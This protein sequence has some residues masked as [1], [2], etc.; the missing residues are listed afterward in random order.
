MVLYKMNSTLHYISAVIDPATE[1]KSAVG[2][3]YK[4]MPTQPKESTT[5]APKTTTTKE[6]SEKVTHF[7]RTREKG[8]PFPW[9]QAT[10]FHPLWCPGARVVQL[11]EAPTVV[12]YQAHVLFNVI[13]GCPCYMNEKGGHNAAATA[14]NIDA[15]FGE[16]FAKERMTRHWFEKFRSGDECLEDEDR[17]WP[18]SLLNDEQ[19]K[20]MVE[21]HPR[22]AV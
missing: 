5:P 16:N 15:A 1:T 20:A 3:K 14:R 11:E 4:N 18:P 9:R 7:L 22:R 2:D 17:G 6:K 8:E 10:K 12:L 21:A 19:L 13:F